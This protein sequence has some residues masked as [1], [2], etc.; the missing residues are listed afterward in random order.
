[1]KLNS[2]GKIWKRKDRSARYARNSV[3]IVA[4][5]AVTV[6]ASLL[7]VPMALD[8]LGVEEYGVWIALTTFVGW[9]SFFDLGL[10]HGLRNK[11]AHTK[12]KGH[13]EEARKYVSTAFF[14]LLAIGTGVFLV[15]L[16]AAPFIDWAA[17]LNASPALEGQ[18]STLALFVVG[19]FCVRLT[20]NIVSIMQTADQHP[21]V[22]AWI[23]AGGNVLSLGA[24]YL[25]TRFCE[26]SVLYLGVALTVSQLFPLLVAF[27]VCFAG[28]YRPYLPSAAHFSRAHIRRIFS[29]GVRFFLIQVTA[30]VLFQSNNVI[31]AHTAGLDQVSEFNIAYKYL[32]VLYVV[33]SA[34][35]T[36]FWSATTEAYAKGDIGWIKKNV[37]RLNKLWVLLVALGV[38]MI[39]A[40]PLAY[41]LWLRDAV[42]PD[43]LLL[44][45]LFAYFACLGRSFLYRNFMNGVGKISL[46]F[47][48]TL[49]QSALHIPLAI[50]AGKAWGVYGVVS[51]MILW[52]FTNALWEPVQFAKI[53]DARAKGIWNK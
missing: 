7:L 11:Y 33:F 52:A 16:A 21:A 19:M 23:V 18:L 28:G 35:V 26:P 1:M 51:V 34:A 6:L 46:Q 43:T 45:L 49:G 25:V 27:A 24:V 17:L 9:F 3:L 48:V 10:G 2:L 42:L 36:P 13:L 30:L 50:F 44:G 40:A 31:I 41:R 22:P 4:A 20:V 37:T 38:A 47:Y 15:Y 39:L 12:A 53:V 29:L 8:Y 5:K 14:V 32:S